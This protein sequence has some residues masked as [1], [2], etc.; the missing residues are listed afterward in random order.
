MNILVTGSEGF[1]GKNL[2]PVLEEQGHTVTGYDLE[3]GQD[4][5]DS[6][7]E[8]KILYTDAVIHLAAKV[9]VGDSFQNP[10]ETFRVNVLG[11]ARVLQICMKYKKKLV[12]PSSASIYHPELSPYAKSK[13]MAEDLVWEARRDLPITI[14][15]LFNIYG[16]GMNA[17]SGAIIHRFF[18]DKEITV[19]GDGE[20]TRDY[21]NVKDIVNIIVS[22]LDEK[23]NG[24]TI[25]CGRGE[26]YST[27]YIAGLFAHYRG[28][29]VKY[30][31]PKRESKWS[32]ANT[33]MLDR[34]YRKRLVTDLQED[35][36]KMCAEGV[37]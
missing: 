27:N 30:D 24:L 16:K 20:Q 17:E 6:G 1:I 12:F 34:L 28:I 15:R 35:I 21:L 9:S 3:R 4:I 31:P 5:L 36:K 22:S 7:L 13:K 2:I 11:T 23:W 14:L 18:N 26:G 8:E 29:K 32:I 33:S 10:T 19:Y 37:I 25:D